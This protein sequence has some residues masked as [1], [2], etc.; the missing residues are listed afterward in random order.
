MRLIALSAAV[1]HA[2]RAIGGRLRQA[3][4][5]PLGPAVR[6]RLAA[7]L[8]LLALL[9]VLGSVIRAQPESTA[10]PP[11]AAGELELRALDV[12]QGDAL[13][14]RLGDATMLVDAGPDAQT[15][16][17]VI[18]PYLH[19]L[20]VNRIDYLV[21]TH[22]DADHIGGAPTI[23]SEF[24]V[25]TIVHADDD[26]RH[27]VMREVIDLAGEAGI[28]IQRV[29]RED[30]LPWHPQVELNVLNPPEPGPDDDNN[31]SIVLQLGYL[32][33][34]ILLTGDIEAAAERELLASGLVGR[35]DVLKMP[36]HGSNSSSTA[37]FLDAVEPQI[38]VVSAGRYNAFDHPRDR[39]LG[40]LRARDAAVFRTDLAGSVTI[41][42]DGR[43]IR[44][45]LE[46]S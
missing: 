15:A 12:G 38:A 10:L 11:L 28:P 27:P 32:E 5:P 4:L 8:L 39:A 44:V 3:G 7:L 19:R 13:L 21:L 36:H 46:R 14:T 24:V 41:R 42:T 20:G 45:F 23:M 43:V 34:V 37:E 25:G 9:I 2:V 6:P 29:E 31:R 26:L 30:V 18:A 33:S 35:A 22:S 17:A 16:S 40:R 1:I